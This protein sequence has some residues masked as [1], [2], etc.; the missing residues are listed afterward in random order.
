MNRYFEFFNTSL[1]INKN[2]YENTDSFHT[3]VNKS[4]HHLKRTLDS[5][6]EIKKINDRTKEETD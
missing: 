3:F 4:I 6:E 2:N 5:L 1:D